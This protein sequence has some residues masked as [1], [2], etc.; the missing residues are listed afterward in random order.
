MVRKKT[1]SLYF[2]I[3]E[4]TKAIVLLFWAEIIKLII[5]KGKGFDFFRLKTGKTKTLIKK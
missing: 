2:G 3:M 5:E 1:E 4:V